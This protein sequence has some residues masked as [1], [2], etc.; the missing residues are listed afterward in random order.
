MDEVRRINEDICL[1]PYYPEDRITLGWYQDLE[2]C[3]QVDNIDHPYDLERL[4]KMYNHLNSHGDCYY[5]QYKGKLV[6]D[7]SLLNNSEVT[8][9]ISKEHQNKKIGR[10]C[11]LEMMN[12]AKEKGMSKIKASIYSFNTQSQRMF[13]SVGFIKVNNELY[14]YYL[15]Q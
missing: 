3:K 4:H 8:I 5:I 10:K 6:G 2:L 14:E 9:V 15:E 13:E 7:C 12:L 11:I 1:I